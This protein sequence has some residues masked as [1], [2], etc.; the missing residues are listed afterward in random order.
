[1][2]TLKFKTSLKCQGCVGNL[3]FYLDNIKEVSSWNVDLNNPDKI[4]EVSFENI[5]KETLL[6]QLK[7]SGY[8]FVE[9]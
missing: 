4:L 6:E 1:M 8:S 2:Q 9:I 3:K 5:S 7:P